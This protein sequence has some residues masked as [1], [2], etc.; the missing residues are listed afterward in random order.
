MRKSRTFHAVATAAL[1]EGHPR[2]EALALATAAVKAVRGK[3]LELT[4]TRLARCVLEPGQGV[5]K[6]HVLTAA[7]R[8]ETDC[9]RFAERRIAAWNT[10]HGHSTNWRLSGTP[11]HERPGY[12]TF[13]YKQPR[14]VE[15]EHRAA[16][17]AEQAA[18]DEKQLRIATLRNSIQVFKEA[19]LPAELYAHLE[20]ELQALLTDTK[21]TI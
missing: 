5:L 10:K 17:S 14:M 2:H 6:I 1:A 3:E 13:C 4:R 9:R 16:I 20:E 8:R 11:A 18:Q 12:L 19:A 21:V 15:A 7:Q